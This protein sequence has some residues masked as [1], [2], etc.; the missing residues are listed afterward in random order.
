[1]PPERFDHF[2]ARAN[3]AY[4]AQREF[5]ADFVTAPELTQVFGE[6][7]GA[8]AK[9]VWQMLGAPADIML[10]EAGG[11][12]GVMMADAL[13]A[14]AAPSVHFIEVSP[15]LRAEQAARVPQAHWHDGLENLPDRTNDSARQ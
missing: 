5:G 8:W 1:M 14:W 11:G 13:R 15:R 2:M 10:V 4:Y 12:R 7:L 3:A 6:L 9:V